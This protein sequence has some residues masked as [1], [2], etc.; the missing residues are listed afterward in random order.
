MNRCEKCGLRARYDKNPQSILGR[1]WKWH[2]GWC[3]GWKSYIR[4]LPDE[5]RKKLSEYYR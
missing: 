3:P 4:S 5:E 2:I 1:I